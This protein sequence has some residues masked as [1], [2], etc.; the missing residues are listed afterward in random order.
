[1][2]LYKTD[3][4]HSVFFSLP[5]WYIGSESKEFGQMVAAATINPTQIKILL[6]GACFV[7]TFLHER[8]SCASCAL[9]PF[10]VLSSVLVGAVRSS[11]VPL[12]E[13]RRL[14]WRRADS[15]RHA[16]AR[17]C[18]TC[19]RIPPTSL[20]ARLVAVGLHW[21]HRLIIIPVPKEERRCS[22]SMVQS[23]AVR[24]WHGG[25]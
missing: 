17:L 14:P 8:A 1:M 13:H 10:S 16:E 20:G 7:Y 5:F 25:V 9:V 22:E 23:R 11:T 24:M 15:P 18:R 19:K 12:A 21:C 4:V 6:L 3:R 2:P